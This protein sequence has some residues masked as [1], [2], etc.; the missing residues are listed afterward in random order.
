L[1]VR[2]A[3][4][5]LFDDTPLQGWGARLNGRYFRK[6]F[7]AIMPQAIAVWCRSLG[8][9]VHY[10]TYY[11]QQDPLSLIPEDIDV[12]I[13]GSFTQCSALAY[14]LGVIFRR[15][16]VLTVI[17]GPHARSFPTD[18][19]RFFDIVVKDCDKALIADILKQRFDPPVV[20]S[21][22]RPATDLPSVEERMP[23]IS[24]ASFHNGRPLIT[25]MV[26]ILASS[27]CPYSCNFCVDWNTPYTA[28]PRERI[29][30]D[31][32]YLARHFPRVLVGYHDPNFAVRFDKMMDLIDGLPAGP[33]NPYAMESSL[34]ILKP[35]RLARLEQTHCVY[36]APGIESWI[37]YSNKA[38]VSARRGREKLNS[39]IAHIRL[40]SRY[41]PGVQVNFMFGGES[42]KGDE[43][44]KL[45]KE[46][47]EQLPEV[48]PAVNIP[49]PF[50]GTPLYDQLYREGRILSALPFA[51]YYTPNLAITLKN[52]DPRTFYAH[53]IDMY[54]TLTSR[55]M[56]LKRVS[57]KTHPIIRFIH[58]LRTWGKRS[59]L[60]EFRRIY[61][62]LKENRELLA[63][64]EGRSKTLPEFYHRRFEERL[65]RYAEV[66]PPE[67]RRPV[68]EPPAAV[69]LMAAE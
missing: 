4:I 27:G 48:W 51:F 14:A 29:E 23:E 5:D 13:V 1:A 57:A 56:L 20:V 24:K 64:H 46:F 52:Y 34:S 6:Q 59:E 61:T 15:R 16:G 43:P 3:I 45:T 58:G 7:M 49:T 22:G 19:L 33:R 36:V 9:E 41:V 67:A 12:L 54:E 25:S 55:A 38:A 65:G 31:L 53:M 28:F 32:K 10:A 44:V 40:L 21:S 69:S 30:A 17:G 62:L 26:P 60:A 47:I 50:G 39:V 35:E 68:L 8:H 11:G 2:V 66:L 37:D 63:F 42:D 18:C